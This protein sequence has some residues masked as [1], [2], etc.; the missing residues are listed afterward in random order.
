M[1]APTIFPETQHIELAELAVHNAAKLCGLE[2][3]DREFHEAEHVSAFVEHM[4]RIFAVH[5]AE[6]SMGLVEINRLMNL[7][8][9]D[10]Q[11][12]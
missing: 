7:W 11:T 8:W 6:I 9:K 4:I 12:N 3:H 5:R 2:L 1:G 10:E